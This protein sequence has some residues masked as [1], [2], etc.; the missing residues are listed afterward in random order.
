MAWG[1]VRAGK[2]QVAAFVLA[3]LN[4]H[5]DRQSIQPEDQCVLIE[6]SF[7]EHCGHGGIISDV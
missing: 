2:L 1:R 7:L 5:A 6:S 4:A 3:H